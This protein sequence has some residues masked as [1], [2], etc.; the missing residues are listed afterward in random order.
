M[1]VEKTKEDHPGKMEG[2]T[3]FNWLGFTVPKSLHGF[4]DKQTQVAK[5]TVKLLSGGK[6]KFQPL[7]DPYHAT[8]VWYPKDNKTFDFDKCHQFV[9]K[10]ELRWDE[11]FWGD[12]RYV[13]TK[14]GSIV[15]IVEIDD[16]F[17]I[18]GMRIEWLK[19]NPPDQAA[20]PSIDDPTGPKTYH[21]HVSVGYFVEES[22]T[23]KTQS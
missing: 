3:S 4:L 6:L 15:A 9:S 12:L 19:N 23:N 7:E 13:R 11:I 22:S 5:Q 10:Y 17:P 2:Q 1:A 21:P 8:F 14:K 18:R 16:L 20:V